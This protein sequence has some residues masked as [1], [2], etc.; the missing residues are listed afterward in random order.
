[1]RESRVSKMLAVVVITPVL[2][3]TL[4]VLVFAAREMRGETMLS[5]GAVRNVAEATGS[6]QASEV[7]RFLRAGQDPN[8]VWTVRRDIISS[9]ITEVTALEAAVWSRHVQLIELLDREGAIADEAHRRELACLAND[10][11]PPVEDIVKYLAPDG[12]AGCEPGAALAAVVARSG[13]S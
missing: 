2:A 4:A 13:P 9:T 1:M 11:V 7:L 6:G 3:A 12:T 5:D 10:L 8:Q